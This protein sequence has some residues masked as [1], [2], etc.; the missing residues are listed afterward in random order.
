MGGGRWGGERAEGGE[1]DGTAASDASDASKKALR[2]AGKGEF[3]EGK[4]GMLNK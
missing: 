3:N 1:R 4:P 2:T